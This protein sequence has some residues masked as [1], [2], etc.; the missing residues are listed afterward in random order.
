MLASTGLAALAVAGSF[1]S[2]ASAQNVPKF[3]YGTPNANAPGVVGANSN[4]PTNPK[5]P[6]LNTPINQSEWQQR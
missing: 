2:G 5:Q 1:F 3:Q 6:S 4:G